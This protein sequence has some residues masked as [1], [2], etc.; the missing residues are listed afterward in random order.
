[1]GMLGSC[2]CSRLVRGLLGVVAF[3]LLPW[4]AI[5]GETTPQPAPSLR[6]ALADVRLREVT[7]PRPLQQQPVARRSE[8]SQSTPGTESPAFFKTTTGAV[9]LAVMAIGAGYAIYSASNDRI[10]SPGKG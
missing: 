8:K 7:P 1:V 5:A 9:V 4:P 3:S 10:H 2:R 6:A